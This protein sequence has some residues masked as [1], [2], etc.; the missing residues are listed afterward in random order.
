MD[1]QAAQQAAGQPAR[2]AHTSQAIVRPALRGS[3]KRHRLTQQQALDKFTAWRN[4]QPSTSINGELLVS[5]IHYR[6]ATAS[7]RRGKGRKVH[8]IHCK[9]RSQCDCPKQLKK[10]TLQEYLRLLSSNRNSPPELVT[11]ISSPP[12]RDCL[13]QISLKQARGGIRKR[14]APYLGQHHYEDIMDLGVAKSFNADLLHDHYKA[15]LYAQFA[16]FLANQRHSGSRPVELANAQC[17]E[18][19]FLTGISE[20]PLLGLNLVDRKMTNSEHNILVPTTENFCPHRMFRTY[21]SRT[22]KGGVQLG[23]PREG[24]D[25]SPFVYPRFKRTS[26]GLLQPDKTANGEW[27]PVLVAVLNKVLREL[28]D[29]LGLTDRLQGF[30][31]GDVRSTAALT[32]AETEDDDV[33]YNKR[34]GWANYSKQGLRYTR[35]Q[36]L[37]PVMRLQRAT[38]SAALASQAAAF[39][40]AF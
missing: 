31:L 16:S 40:D 9:N 7:A 2:A 25:L 34:M 21:I 27:Q 18:T 22:V 24:N 38:A 26:T 23:V 5:Y 29:E 4:A 10:S 35:A 17:R 36:A 1:A 20:T 32:L 15:T 12:V 11:A 30:S 39:A 6:N 8:S 28:I 13:A 37:Q 3:A 14:A 33:A 19:V